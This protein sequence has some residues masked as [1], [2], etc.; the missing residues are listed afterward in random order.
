MGNGGQRI[1]ALPDLDVVVA[2]TAGGYDAADQ[3][4]TPLAVLDEVL[5]AYGSDGLP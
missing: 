4:A 5:R 1:F 2:V 3:S